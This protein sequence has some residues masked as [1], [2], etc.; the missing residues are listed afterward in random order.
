M[1]APVDA[2]RFGSG[3]TV[4]R[5]EDPAL[6]AGRGQFTDDLTRPGQ[7]HLVFLRS[8]YAHARI[9]S[10]DWAAVRASPGVVAVL[11]AEDVRAAGFDAIGALVEAKGAGGGRPRQ[12][13]SDT[14]VQGDDPEGTR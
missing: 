3:H 14:L 7:T 13:L 10:I 8:P 11:T 2:L 4:R 5:I 12:R 1:N 9:L 6:V